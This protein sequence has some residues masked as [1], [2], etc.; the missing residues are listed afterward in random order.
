ME[1]AG[2]VSIPPSRVVVVVGGRN[3]GGESQKSGFAWIQAD[4]SGIR[5][6][7]VGELKSLAIMVYW[8]W[9]GGVMTQYCLVRAAMVC[10]DHVNSRRGVWL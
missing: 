10:L 7:F 9:I 3:R 5:P 6:I 1:V 8:V 4:T 2:D